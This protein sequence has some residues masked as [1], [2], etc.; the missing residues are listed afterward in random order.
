MADNGHVYGFR[1]YKSLHADA[2]PS[3]RRVAI[4]S[5]NAAEYHAGDPVKI[6]STG[7]WSLCAAGDKVD[8]IVVRIGP[9]YNG[10]RFAMHT[11]YLP[12]STVYGTNYERQSFLYVM[13]AER[14]IFECDC[15]DN[16]TAT[17][18]ATYLSY[19]GENIEMVLGD[20]TSGAADPKL[21][22]S[23]HATTNTL[24]WRIHG[25]SE[26]MTFLDFSAQNVKLYVT[27]NLTA[28]APWTT[29]GT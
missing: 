24:S 3:P 22:I 21:D 4:A 9:Y 25:I 19:I 11:D 15:D 18:Y 5:N 13:P 1:P 2:L 27:P 29:T 26:Q 20:G 12:K 6:L 16:T 8:G 7:Y 17:D 10:T 14:T 23:T 28:E